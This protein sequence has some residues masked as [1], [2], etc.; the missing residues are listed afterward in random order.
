M[1]FSTPVQS[2][3][4]LQEATMSIR[5]SSAAA[6][7]SCLLLVVRSTPAQIAQDKPRKASPEDKA[8]FLVARPDLGDPFFKESVVL[9]F[10][11]SVVA[12][13][14][15]VV[16]LIINRPA[17][18]AL[19][20]I[21]PNDKSLKSRPETPYFGGPVDPQVLGVVFRSSQAAK[22]ATLLFGDI[23]VSFDSDFI[24]QL[25]NKPEKTPDLRLFVGRSQWTSAQLDNEI[26]KGAWYSVRAETSLIFSASPQ[27][28]WR[29][30][31]ERAEPGPVA[32]LSGERLLNPRF[33]KLL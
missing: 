7:I 30:L 26:D 5:R 29:T 16:G 28:L 19:G 17:R 23:Y 33:W 3:P 12:V 25:L 32:K 9:I 18:V 21:F 8:R 15:L 4:S 13:E 31:F 10:P 1:L 2:D 20:E 24:K 14:D 11:S 6:L 22:Q 27:V